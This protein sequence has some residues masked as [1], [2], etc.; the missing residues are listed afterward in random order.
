MPCDGRRQSTPQHQ[1]RA[2]CMEK[3][4]KRNDDAGDNNN[5]MEKRKSLGTTRFFG[6][7]LQQCHFVLMFFGPGERYGTYCFRKYNQRAYTTT[8]SRLR[9]YPVFPSKDER[10]MGVMSARIS[11]STHTDTNTY[12][13]RKAA[14]HRSTKHQSFVAKYCGIGERE[15]DGIIFVCMTYK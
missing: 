11:V 12:D 3:K 13:V 6:G 10:W 7:F 4:W 2:S 8:S 1:H 14:C 9:F 5:I 15:R